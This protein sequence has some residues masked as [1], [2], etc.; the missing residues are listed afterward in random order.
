MVSVVIPLLQFDLV[1]GTDLLKDLLK[2]T[3]DGIIDNRFSILNTDDQ[4][5]MQHEH[6]VVIAIEYHR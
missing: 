1:V 3:R 2:V 6:C 4:M 5:I